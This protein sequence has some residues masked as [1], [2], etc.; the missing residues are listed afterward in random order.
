MENKAGTKVISATYCCGPIPE[1]AQRNYIP[2]AQIWGD[3]YILWAENNVDG[4]RSVY[5][6]QLPQEQVSALLQSAAGQ[7]FF[8]WS[9]LYTSPL[10]QSDLPNKCLT[11]AMTSMSQS[12]CEY[13][14]GAPNAFH[15]LY[16]TI[17]SGAGADGTDYQPQTGYLLSYPAVVP[18]QGAY[19]DI[20]PW[21]AA[22]MGF[23]LTDATGGVW[24]PG[25]VLERTWGC[26]LM[27]TPGGPWLARMAL[28][29]L[30]RCNS[31]A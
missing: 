3:G 2:D 30:S 16:E 8:T 9:E 5:E 10:Q 14:E 1:F 26:W 24:R 4:T 25:P 20:P 6:A 13:G 27:P 15:A 12:V 31:P 17:A 7:G 21:D 22:E 18:D 11:I 19:A 23:S 29:T 28:F